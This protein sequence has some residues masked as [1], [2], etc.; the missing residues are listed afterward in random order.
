MTG[1]RDDEI[2]I[3]GLLRFIWSKKLLICVT[4]AIFLVMAAIYLRIAT[5]T[6]SVELQVTAAPNSGGDSLNSALGSLSGLAS[7]A[8]INLAGGQNATQFELYL[9]GLHSREVAE[10]VMK[11]R[12]LLPVIFQGE[13]NQQQQR[14]QQPRDPL[15]GVK[16]VIKYILGV[17]V[18]PWQ[19]PNAARMQDYLQTF[20]K[21]RRNPKSP[22]V[23]IQTNHRDPDFAKRLLSRVHNETDRKLRAMALARSQEYIR[24][25]SQQ[26]EIVQ[27]AEHRLAIAQALS[28]QEKMR[29]MT[30][31][32][33][34]FAAEPF[35]EPAASFKPTRPQPVILLAA[36]IFA[37]GF[38]ALLAI[39]LIYV[40]RY[41]VAMTA[42]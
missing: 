31:A 17:P 40:G 37:G 7:I 41:R 3:A 25:L 23:T 32:D 14:F 24:Y 18:R 21:I 26:L 33:I 13:W 12:S 15:A 19:A 38:F 36:S 5:Y 8:G 6:Y 39:T 1:R 4:V 20:I 29:M 28:E 22:V 42:A 34:P 27:V 2:D 35:G 16:R 10:A 11:D 30:S 9:E